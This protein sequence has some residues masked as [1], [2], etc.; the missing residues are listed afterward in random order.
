M[1][2]SEAFTEEIRVAP[3]MSKLRSPGGEFAGE[4]NDL[5]LMRAQ[6]LVQVGELSSARQALEG[7]PLAPGNQATL[8]Q[9]TDASRCH[10]N[11]GNRCH[12]KC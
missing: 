10:P 12:Q 3:V 6:R 5:E 4:H 2:R 11:H 9:V 1:A 7:A 8:G